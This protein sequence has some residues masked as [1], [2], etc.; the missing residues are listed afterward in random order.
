MNNSHDSMSRIL[1]IEK[2]INLLLELIKRKEKFLRIAWQ[3]HIQAIGE[4]RIYQRRWRKKKY[5]I[6]KKHRRI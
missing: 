2:E 3:N 1:E 5:A 6:Q 4:K